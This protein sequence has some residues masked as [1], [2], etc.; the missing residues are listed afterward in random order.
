[1][2]TRGKTA[3]CF[4]GL[5]P[6]LVDSQSIPAG[7]STGEFSFNIPEYGSF[8]V[9]LTDPESAASAQVSFYASGWGY[10]P[11][12]VR[13]PSR[14]ELELDRDEYRPGQSAKVLVKA[15]F[16]G[17]L[18]LSVERD[19][20]YHA[21]IHRLEGNTAELSVPVTAEFAR[22]A[23]TDGSGRVSS[24]AINY[25]PAGRGDSSSSPLSSIG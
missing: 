7:E 8:R 13:N 25:S 5:Y 14:I 22:S 12:A 17:R 18:L 1:M 2:A 23:I 24:P 16:P 6:E 21:S 4:T 15:P 3:A 19:G 20:V 10:S 11:W 9:V